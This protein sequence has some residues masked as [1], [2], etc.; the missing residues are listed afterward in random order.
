MDFLDKKTA[1]LGGIV[2]VLSGVLGTYWFLFVAFL[3]FNI[4]DYLTGVYK[5]RV[6]KQESSAK[7]LDGILKKIMYWVMICVAFAAAM[8]LNEIGNIVG[9]D[10]GFAE[11]FGWFTLA[12]LLI[13]EVR[14]ILENLVEAGIA[15]P[16]FF[17][18]GLKVTEKILANKMEIEDDETP[19]ENKE[20]Q[21]K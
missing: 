10:L 11:M 19:Q 20:S 2:A 3:F 15:V 8:I 9:V 1:V 5:S 4:G 6:L 18:K 13:N 17:I 7:G 12:T 16:T 14:S 21:N